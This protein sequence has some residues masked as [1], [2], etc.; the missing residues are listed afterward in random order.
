MH[1]KRFVCAAGDRRA[2]MMLGAVATAALAGLCSNSA[3]ASIV[4]TSGNSSVTMNSTEVGNWTVAGI[5]QLD[6]EE[7]FYRIGNSG[8]QSPLSALT[9]VSATALSSTVEQL[10]YGSSSGFQVVVKY[11]LTGGAI[12]SDSSDLTETVKV[13]NPG[14][15]SQTFHLFDYTNFN[16]D[17]STTGQTVTIT[18]GNTA[19][20]AGDGWQ[21]QTVVSGKPNE[22]E[23]SNTAA[24]PD[25]LSHISSTSKAYTLKDVAAAAAGD[26]EWAFEWDLN[27]GCDSSCLISIDKDIKAT[28]LQIVPEPV[29]GAIVLLGLGGLS[30]MRPKRRNVLA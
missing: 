11:S 4:L 16:L 5:N 21:A 6:Q 17:D 2:A 13:S 24:S 28:P 27:V 9:P 3:R 8:G 10:T 19:T 20:V 7:F 22:Y 25:L 15:S 23:A 30:M 12:G 14:M 26:G 18:G 1:F 29:S